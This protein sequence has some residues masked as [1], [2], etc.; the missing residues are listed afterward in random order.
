M[1]YCSACGSKLFSDA[2][3]CEQCGTKLLSKSYRDAELESLEHTTRPLQ[4]KLVLAINYLVTAIIV[5]FAFI[6]LFTP[7][8]IY[9]QTVKNG[10]LY[11]V[12]TYSY[13]QSIVGCIF[14]LV[15]AGLFLK[16]TFKLKNYS[17]KARN[18]MIA[19]YSLN[20]LSVLL[21]LVGSTVTAFFII[22]NM[23][24]SL[25]VIVTLL[26]RKDLQELWD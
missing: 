17:Y 23:A 22:L 3:Y 21:T 9:E 13:A 14:F 1:I 15:L 10:Q 18:G 25:F 6:T 4:F 20:L 19:F 8:T 16:I 12:I 26:F 2:K 7:T 11:T 24:V 5:V